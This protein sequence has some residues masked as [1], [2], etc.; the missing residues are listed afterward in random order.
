MDLQTMPK[1]E[2]KKFLSMDLAERMMR[3]EQTVSASFRKYVPYYQT[4]YYKSMSEQQRN[5]FKK[6]LRDKN[7]KKFV[8]F[9]LLIFP[10]FLISLF[11][12][13][14][15][16][17]VISSNVGMET[18]LTIQVILVILVLILIY[19][20]LAYFLMNKKHEKKFI[21]HLQVLEHGLRKNK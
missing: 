11:H 12:I 5:D 21:H 16:A 13:S 9:S 7:K 2:K 14:F 17:K 10:L 15:T 1:N 20:F 3:V 4:E 18:S 6:Y 8:L 19:A